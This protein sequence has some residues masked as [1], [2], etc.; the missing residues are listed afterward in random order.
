MKLLIETAKGSG[1]IIEET[2]REDLTLL[3]DYPLLS[4]VLRVA[5][6]FNAEVRQDHEDGRALVTVSVRLSEVDKFRS[7]IVDATGGTVSFR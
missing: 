3:I 2:I 5:S 7:E 4:N 1:T 6:R